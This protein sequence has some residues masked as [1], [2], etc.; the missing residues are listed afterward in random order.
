MRTLLYIIVEAM[1]PLLPVRRY[2]E[3]DGQFSGWAYEAHNRASA[4]VLKLFY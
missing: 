1:R 4:V 3:T 2:T